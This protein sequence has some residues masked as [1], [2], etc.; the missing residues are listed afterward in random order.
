[1]ETVRHNLNLRWGFGEEIIIAPRRFVIDDKIRYVHIVDGYCQYVQLY[2]HL[3]YI[4]NTCVQVAKSN[5]LKLHSNT[6]GL[7]FNYSYWV[8]NS[9]KKTIKVYI[10]E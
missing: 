4:N 5:F 10:C 3:R 9:E 6:K 2:E 1:M 8:S 7:Y